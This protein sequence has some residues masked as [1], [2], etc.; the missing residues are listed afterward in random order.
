A[1]EEGASYVGQTVLPK[2]GWTALMY[3][4]RQGAVGAVKALAGAGADLDV[5]DPDG[6]SALI[7]AI[8]NGHYDAAEVLAEYGADV[9]LP[10][11]AGMTPLYAVVDMHTLPT[12]FGRP[13]LT[14]AVV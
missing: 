6:T 9:N 4:A 3:A 13:D 12:T 1:L 8:I 14:A 7:F 10:D 5:A 2:G 11:R